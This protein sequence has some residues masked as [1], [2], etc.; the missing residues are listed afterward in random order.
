MC[1]VRPSPS[2]R[3][4]DLGLLLL[5]T[6]C[7]RRLLKFIEPGAPAQI[8]AIGD[9]GRYEEPFI[10]HETGYRLDELITKKV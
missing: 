6:I 7:H 1:L 10:F 8:T 5:S 2:N 9:R 3:L 4:S